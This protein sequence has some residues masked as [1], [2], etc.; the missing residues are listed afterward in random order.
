MPDHLG[1]SLG[2][3][4]LVEFL[5][6]G[7][8]AS[9]Y[10]G[11]H[12]YLHSHA[13]LK[14]VRV[15]LT[16]VQAQQFLLEA[17]ILVRLRHPHI[18]RVL[19]FAVEQGTPVLMMDYAPGGTLRE[20]HPRGCRLPLALVS[21]YLQQVAEALQYA[22]NHNVIHR[23]VKPENMLRSSEQHLLLSDFGLALLTPSPDLLST[24]Q[25]AGTLPYTAPEQL[26][27]KPTFASDQYALGI[28]TY[29][30]LSG[31]RPFEGSHWQIICHHLYDEPPP[32]RQECP[33]L[34]ATVEAVVAR[35]LAKDPKHRFVSVQAF[36]QA[37]TRAYQESVVHD[38][39]DSQVTVPLKAVP[40]LSNVPSPYHVSASSTTLQGAQKIFLSASPADAEFAVRL[41]MDLKQQGIEVV[42]HGQANVSHRSEQV[43]ALREAMRTVQCVFVVVSP[44]TR[45][46]QTIKEHLR[47]AGMYRRRLVFVWAA[48][49][50]MVTLL[51]DVWGQTGHVDVIDAR[52]Q[53]YE[54][55]LKEL[56]ACLRGDGAVTPAE[57][58]Q[59]A[60]PS[61]PA[62]PR[63]PYKGLR[64]FGRDDVADFFGR[65]L[66]VEDLVAA[67]ACMVPSDSPKVSGARLLA[68][69]GPSGSGKSS[70]VRAG[71]LPRLQNGAVSPSQKWVYLEPMVP[72]THP[73]EGLALTLFP[74]F[75]ERSMK[76]IRQDLEDDTV[77]GLHLLTTH[78]ATRPG[79][80]GVLVVDQFEE[81][82]SHTVPEEIRQRF[83]KLLITAVTEPDGSLIV[84][85]TLRADF[86]DRLLSYPALFRLIQDHQHV[87]LPMDLQD[88]RTV[89]EQPAR[90]PDV[91]LSFEG[92][93]VGDLLFETQGQIGA[94]PLLE[95]TL[96]QLFQQRR[97]HLLTLSSYREM[98]GVKGALSRHAEQTYTRLPS[99]EHR[100]LARSLFTRLID[101][102]ATEQD[103]TRRR[104][105]LSE[106]EFD[107]A[108]QTRL[109]QDTM[110]AFIAA[111]LLTTN[112]VAEKTTVEVSHEAVIREWKRLTDWMREA[113][114]DISL[115]RDISKD[116]TEWE[117]HGKPK[118]RLY[119]GSQLKEARTWA[120]RNIPSRNEVAFLRASTAQRIRSVASVIV[121]VLLLL[122]TTGGIGWF[123][124]RPS[125]PDPTRVVTLSDNGTGSLRWAIA[126]APPKSTITFD[127]RLHGTLLLTSGDLNI[128]KDLTLL[129]PGAGKFSISSGKSGHI[130]HVVHDAIVA[131]SGVTFKESKTSNGVV[132]NEGTLTLSNSAI[133]GNEAVMGGGI[134]NGGTLMLSNSTISGNTA[135]GLNSQGGG[136]YNGGTL[137]LSNSTISGNTATSPDGWGGGG[138]YNDAG[139]R[140][141]LI[142]STIS[143][144]RANR[145]GGIGITDRIASC[146]MSPVRVTL[147]YC[148]VYGNTADMGGGIRVDT[149]F[150]ES[151]VT[152]R[153][154]IVAG[155]SAQSSPDIAGSLAT[156]GYNVV[157]D[158][159]GTM[160]PGSPELQ[161]TDKLGI[162]STAVGIDP[163]LRNNGG[164]T[165]TQALLPGSPAL[166]A[167]PLQY[168]QVK[169]IFNDKSRMY[170]DQRG[171]KRPDENE[172][173]CDIGVYERAG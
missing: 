121:I 93:L 12:R 62:E 45:F 67:I 76:S 158:P 147:L 86:Y 28:V 32:L 15:S 107:D 39:S 97:G 54:V 145:G 95:F 154:S 111:R 51:L 72:G 78:L 165:W 60:S 48:G 55:A 152:M 139:G 160:L 148:T 149:I 157:G 138:I 118:D 81:L 104:T 89:I 99:D 88:L 101:P 115:Q 5:G 4:D 162:S 70:V 26:R 63:N 61:E 163:I 123:L 22:H 35:A 143:G 144:N 127:E 2:N 41:E 133:S 21:N 58:S 83:L 171:M 142:N 20:R 136:I 85:L 125:P 159:S 11:K 155:N 46:S 44:H 131:I 130:V 87:L 98:G 150:K 151:Q 33:E 34:P 47:I 8:Q 49:E 31:K 110:E 3:Y 1:Q 10:L 37:F 57:L 52:G 119:R 173:A 17:Q 105:S 112:E 91:Q 90:L 68:V 100:R 140:L 153:A 25:M 82:F 30:W 9:V 169:E 80:R 96:D 129:G 77:R 164:S 7:G 43:D 74:Y 50:D 161:S 128:A 56:V 168:C 137:M 132:F 40:R 122:S 73:V 19:E 64:A 135:T 116:A 53:R 113:R 42:H 71:L 69:L 134:W 94:L 141:T 36:A 170:I 66:F 166:D 65:D 92:N 23:D 16:D 29:E 103:T 167:I 124:S 172:S 114:E 109:L 108:T 79:T 156:F 102:G 13:A 24:Q 146:C 75:P 14:V 59:S 120:R 38:D 117:H 126:L 6:Q 27:G 18:V 106:F 84:V